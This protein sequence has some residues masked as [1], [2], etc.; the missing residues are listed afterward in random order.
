MAELARVEEVL[1]RLFDANLRWYEGLGRVTADYTQAVIRV[2]TDAVTSLV[3][4]RGTKGPT[5]APST[6][7]RPASARAAALVLE[8]D[9]GQVAQGAVAIENRLTR[10]VSAAVVTSAFANESGA[11]TWPT[12]RVSP[13]KV[14][15]EPGA[16]T[17]VQIGVLIDEQLVPGASYRGE[18]SVPELSDTPIPILLRRRLA[19]GEPAIPPRA[20]GDDRPAD[21]PSATDSVPKKARSRVAGSPKRRRAR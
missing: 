3:K 1:K 13:A 5:P 16:R 10:A 4:T 7:A 2:W 18:V 14:D 20:S 15:L 6:G 21:L 12:L 17:L 8:A 11:A 9:L 19:A